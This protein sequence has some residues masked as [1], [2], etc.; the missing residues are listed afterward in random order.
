[1]EVGFVHGVLR[2]SYEKQANEQGFTLGEK[3]EQFE[4]IGHACNLLR[5]NGY[6]TDTQTD[7]IYRKIQKD[8]VEALEKK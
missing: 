2:E 5:M 8:I 4:N 1:M 7:T 3:A 6:L